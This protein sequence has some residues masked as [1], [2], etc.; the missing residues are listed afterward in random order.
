MGQKKMESAEI[1]SELIKKEQEP[2]KIAL[3][4]GAPY[5]FYKT[6]ITYQKKNCT[7][8]NWTN[9]N[10]AREKVEAHYSCYVAYFTHLI[11]YVLRNITMTKV[12]T[13]LIILQTQSFNKSNRVKL[14]YV[15]PFAT[16]R[17]F[18]RR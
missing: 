18:T 9:M 13:T 11:I 7:E 10:Q 6:F 17:M 4:L 15:Y 5:A 3:Y 12:P 1:L 14:N 2:T 8:L 16:N